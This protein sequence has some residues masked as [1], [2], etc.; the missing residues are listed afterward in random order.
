VELGGGGCGTCV[1]GDFGCV[2][3]HF[4]CFVCL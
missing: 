3:G 2:C 1:E 4:C